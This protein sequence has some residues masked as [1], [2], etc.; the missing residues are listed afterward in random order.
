VFFKQ[1]LCFFSLNQQPTT[2]N[3]QPTTKN[4]QPTTNNQKP[5][6]SPFSGAELAVLV[7]FLTEIC[8]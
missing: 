7:Y 4:Q 8:S 1:L 6:K 3:Q 2:K 5:K